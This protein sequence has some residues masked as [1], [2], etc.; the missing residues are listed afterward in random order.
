MNRWYRMQNRERRW[1]MAARRLGRERHLS[2]KRLQFLRRQIEAGEALP[3][4]ARR[5]AH[6][7]LE[8]GHLLRVHQPGMI[9]LMTGKGQAV[10]LDR[11]GDKA[12][13]LVIG[14]GVKRVEYRAHIVT[15]EIGH[16]P[17]Q[18]LVVVLV[19]DR[20]NAGIAVEIAAEML[21]PALAALVD[22]GG[23]ERIRAGVD[24]FAQLLAIRPG[25]RGLQEAAV[26]QRDDAPAEHLE[27][28]VDATEEPVGDHG[29]E[30]LA[31]VIDYPPEIADIVL[32]AFEE[33]LEDVALVE[34]GVTGERNHSARWRVARHQARQTQIVLHQRGKERNA[35]PEP[36]RAGR[37]IDDIAI[38]AAPRVGLGAAQGADAFQFIAALVP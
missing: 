9:V 37:K 21:S 5:H 17:P 38:L 30:A 34:L 12:G 11:I 20:A 13:R 14:N 4:R 22:E 8:G 3:L 18:R 24:P 16:Q 7:L 1:A 6:A 19:E 32:P 33:G 29:V 15:G 2:E 35:N 36:D 28:G 10:T 27:Q 23:V 31:V 25:K 26:F